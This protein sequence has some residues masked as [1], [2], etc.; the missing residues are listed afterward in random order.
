MS[1]R[2]LFLGSVLVLLHASLVSPPSAK[3]N[4]SEGFLRL[5]G[6][7]VY[8]DHDGQPGPGWLAGG[9]LGVPLNPNVA[10]SVNYDHMDLDVL[11]SPRTVDPV[12]AQLEFSTPYRHRLMP[13]AE[14]G[15][16]IYGFGS[17]DF[18]VV[19]PLRSFGGQTAS[20]SRVAPF[21]VNFGAGLSVPFGARMMIDLDARYHQTM[22]SGSLVMGTVGA[23]LSYRLGAGGN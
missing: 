13:R 18:P 15:A 14:V 2:A 5:R 4:A 11:G 3:A 21:G 22:G 8:P 9:A 20:S 19:S 12:T 1:H 7:L 23:G 6:G 16:G 10:L 17:R